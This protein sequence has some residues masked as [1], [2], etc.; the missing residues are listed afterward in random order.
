MRNYLI[1]HVAIKGRVMARLL[2]LDT[3]VLIEAHEVDIKVLIEHSSRHI[4]SHLKAI[5][6]HLTVRKKSETGN[7]Y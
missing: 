2:K 1:I 3:K 7:A 4:Y 5:D 6:L